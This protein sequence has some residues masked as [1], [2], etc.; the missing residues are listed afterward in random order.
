MPSSTKPFVNVTDLWEQPELCPY[1]E[2]VAGTPVNI[3]CT[4]PGR[5]SG[6][7][8]RIT[9]TGTLNT[10]NSTLI[11][12]SMNR[13]RTVTHASMIS[14]IPSVGDQNKTLTCKVYYP[15]VGQSINTR[16]SLNVQCK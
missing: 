11:T 8:P 7:P 13:D 3:T 14:F 1:A 16:L 9:W 5:C 2:L 4:A 15:A 12:Q 6:T 10:A